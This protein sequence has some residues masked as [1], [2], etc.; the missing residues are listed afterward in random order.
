MLQFLDGVHSKTCCGSLMDWAGR[1]NVERPFAIEYLKC[2]VSF[3]TK[4]WCKEATNVSYC[5]LPFEERLR[6]IMSKVTP[7]LR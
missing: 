5:L 7:M 2:T 3:G 4:T 1:A 6:P